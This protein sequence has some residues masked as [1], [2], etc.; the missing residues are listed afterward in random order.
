M[1][2]YKALTKKIAF[3][4][5]QTGTAL[6]KSDIPDYNDMVTDDKILLKDPVKMTH[7]K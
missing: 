6:L 5:N 7:R 3:K 2:F 4:N 1:T